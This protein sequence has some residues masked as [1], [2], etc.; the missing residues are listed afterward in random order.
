MQYI[1]LL[2]AVF[3]D[4]QYSIAVSMKEY[5]PFLVHLDSVRGKWI[6][7]IA[8]PKKSSVSM[9]GMYLV[10]LCHDVMLYH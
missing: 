3:W 2:I 8:K 9:F 10:C 4:L 1:V 7:H 6:A 5:V